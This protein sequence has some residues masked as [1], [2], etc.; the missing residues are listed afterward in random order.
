MAAAGYCL[1]WL[2]ICWQNSYLKGWSPLVVILQKYNSLNFLALASGSPL[3]TSNSLGKYRTAFSGVLLYRLAN[4][5][6]KPIAEGSWKYLLT[7]SSKLL[8]EYSLASC[9]SGF[10]TTGLELLQNLHSNLQIIIKIVKPYIN[11]CCV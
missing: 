3:A 10:M 9:Y 11:H 8:L 5:V 2:R 6:W 7:S 1:K 4:N